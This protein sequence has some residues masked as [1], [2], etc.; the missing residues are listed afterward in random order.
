MQ[1][2]LEA[3]NQ[4]RE[5]SASTRGGSCVYAVVLGHDKQI[6]WITRKAEMVKRTSLAARI[7]R[8]RAHWMSSAIG[9]RF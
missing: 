7:A 1:P 9:G 6:I 3:R 4:R 2:M 8:L 5:M